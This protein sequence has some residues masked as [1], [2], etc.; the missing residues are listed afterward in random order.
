MSDPILCFCLRSPLALAGSSTET[1][2]GLQAVLALCNK[3]DPAQQWVLRGAWGDNNTLVNTVLGDDTKC[4]DVAGW[5]VGKQG[6]PLQSWHCCCRD[7]RLCPGHASYPDKNYNEQ[8]T[9]EANTGRLRVFTAGRQ[10][11]L[12]HRRCNR[13]R[14][15]RWPW[16]R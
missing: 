16:Q 3:T 7:K 5:D 15:P 1:G 4:L 12:C 6:K 9:F 13:Q 2:D 11:G 8:F 14:D 10:P